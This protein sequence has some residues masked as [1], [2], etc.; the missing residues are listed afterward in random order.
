[1]SVLNKKFDVIFA[2]LFYHVFGRFLAPKKMV[3]VLGFC[4]K[5]VR[6]CVGNSVVL[7]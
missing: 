2:L 3:F 1:M 5:K 7:A 6:T 4:A